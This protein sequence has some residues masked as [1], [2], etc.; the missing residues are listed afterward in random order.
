MG[1]QFS[2]PVEDELLHRLINKEIT[3]ADFLTTF[4]AKKAA[5]TIG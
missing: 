1:E 3:A 4:L 5:G 2:L